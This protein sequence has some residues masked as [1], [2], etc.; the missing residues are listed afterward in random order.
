MSI[1]R[2]AAKSRLIRK[3]ILQLAR[4]LYLHPQTDTAV[5]ENLRAQFHD[6]T[7]ES[8]RNHFIYLADNGLLSLTKKRN[9]V[10]VQIRPKGIDVLDGT[11][12]VKGVEPSNP[13]L[14]RLTYKKEIRH[15]ILMYCNTFRD[16]YNED[17]EIHSEFRS[18]GFSNILIEE[19]RFHIWYLF[20]KGFLELKTPELAGDR[21]FMARITAD[22]VDII[23]NNST[24]AGVSNG[25]E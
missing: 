16:I 10:S 22:G 13:Q 18:S 6:I 23:E 21:V 2:T 1:H 17:A 19:V 25:G 5:S 24:D 14:A 12:S 7:S 3:H 8:V 20:N 15:G 11:L 4:E 9:S